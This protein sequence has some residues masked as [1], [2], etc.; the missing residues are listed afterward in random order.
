[1][2]FIKYAIVA[3]VVVV[4]LVIGGLLAFVNLV[5]PKPF[6]ENK[7]AEQTGRTLNVEGDLEWGIWPKVRIKS[8]PIRL[9]NPE[10]FGDQPFARFD[11]FEV[12]LAT[13][14]ALRKDIKM[15]VVKLYGGEINLHRREDGS[16]NWDDFAGE[17]KDKSKKSSGGLDKLPALALG[18]VDIKDAKVTYRDDTTGQAIAL[19]DITAATGALTLGDPVDL[20]VTFN[21]DSSKPNIKGD[22]ALTANISYDLGDEHYVI[23]PLNLVSN[24]T[25]PK[26]P[27]GAT[28]LDLKGKVDA[29]MGDGDVSISGLQFT[30]LDTNLTG[31]LS[32]FDLDRK[33]PGAR[34]TLNLSGKDIATIFRVLESPIANQ[35]AKNKNRAFSAEIDFDANM[36]D[37][38]VAVPTL[39]A[40]VLGTKINGQLVAG[41]ADTDKPRVSGKLDAGGPDLPALLALVGQIQG[42]EGL[43][44]MGTSLARSNAKAFSFATAFN[45]D[46]K[47]GE[48]S[49]SALKGQGLGLD[50]N[51]NLSAG[52]VNDKSGS[53]DGKLNIVGKDLKP[54]L[55][56]IGQGDLAEVVKSLN[57]DTG[58][59][60][61]T[62]NLNL[63]PLQINASVAGKGI[64]NGPVDLKVSAQTANANLANE[65]VNLQDLKVTGLGLNLIG[66]LDASNFKTAPKLAGNLKITPFNLRKFLTQLNQDVPPMADPTTLSN[67][68][69]DI[70]FKG[71]P[72][73]VDVQD[74]T[75]QLDQTTIKGTVMIADV[76]TNDLGFNLKVNEID[77]DRYLP[78][79]DPDDKKV[80]PVTPE[81]TAASAAGDLPLD[82]LKS[83]KVKGDIQ[84][85]KLKISGAEMDNVNVA[86]RARDGDVNV[87]PIKANAYEGNYQGQINIDATGNEAK[88]KT[89]S[90]LSNVQLR[91]LLKDVSGKGLIGGVANIDANFTGQG[92]SSDAIKKSLNGQ[93]KVN[94]GKGTI[95]GLTGFAQMGQKI[96]AVGGL[97][98][99]DLSGLANSASENKSPKELSF[100]SINLTINAKDGVITNDDLLIEAP[101]I[102]ATGAG[103]LIDFHTNTTDYSAEPK[104][105]ATLSGSSGESLEDITGLPSSMLNEL[106]GIPIP[107]RHFGP[108]S[109]RK[110]EIDWDSVLGAMPDGKLKDAFSAGSTVKKLQDNPEE[111]IKEKL[112]DKL[113]GKKEKA[114][115]AAP[116]DAATDATESATSAATAAPQPEAQEAAKEPEDEIKD[117][118]KDLL[119]GLFD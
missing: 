50:L 87:D 13:L 53:I 115:P 15:D 40:D 25:G 80:R 81:T 51:G 17:E 103:T 114:A 66:N 45:A 19:T 22:T 11:E 65:T 63:Q 3:T 9:S 94:I 18:G 86:I 48:V 61:T 36:R 111:L 117:A 29:N 75:I 58:L 12:A 23:E 108:L 96:G 27:G 54:L 79:K 49:V 78:P 39:T 100:S 92:K 32:A 70:L 102:R 44:E 8:G 35:L 101:L 67:F 76:A 57:V 88:V 99:G 26:I 68:G 24:L 93:A 43:R 118:A 83:L 56:A 89:S 14:P 6:L 33:K 98:S 42:N 107:A 10:G 38:N 97:L 71:S 113:L 41:D 106:K 112:F 7:V 59:S 30:G 2:R 37:G 74:L 110:T 69:L 28:T 21:L 116:T 85:K 64:P 20:K 95:R 47:T 105:V 119:K 90:T 77:A 104:I 16:T 73:E 109:S 62:S 5:D 31:E 34:G 55:T 52:N 1:M 60:G 82:L 84:I 91:P 4:A 72:K 46:M